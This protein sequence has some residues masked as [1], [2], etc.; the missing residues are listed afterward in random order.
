M[1]FTI[2]RRKLPKTAFLARSS[3]QIKT[4]ELLHQELGFKVR[5]L[6]YQISH[7]RFQNQD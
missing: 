6:K 3:K 4:P 1:L 5:I 7:L 2:Q